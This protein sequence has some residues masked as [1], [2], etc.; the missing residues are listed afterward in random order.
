MTNAYTP[1]A[2]PG[3]PPVPGEGGRNAAAATPRS[4][5]LAFEEFLASREKD[6]K[7]FGDKRFPIFI[8]STQGG[9]I[10]AASAASTFLSTLQVRN[11]NFTRHLFAVSAVSGGSV[12]SAVFH[13]AISKGL[14]EVDAQHAAAKPL[15]HSKLFI[16]IRRTLA[17]DHLS[18]V[19]GLVA[20][21]YLEKV[22]PWLSIRRL[23]GTS[24][25]PGRIDRASALEISLACAFNQQVDRIVGPAGTAPVARRP[26]P[27][28][29]DYANIKGG[30]R[31][32]FASHAP[33]G[34]APSL[35]L[36][37]TFAETGKRVAFANFRLKSAGEGSLHS[38][39]DPDFR[40]I[41]GNPNL[42]ADTS[43]ATAAVASARFPILMPAFVVAAASGDKGSAEV[44]KRWNF[45]D[46]GYADNSGVASAA[47]M[48]GALE[49]FLEKNPKYK[50][51]LKLL[52]LTDDNRERKPIDLDGTSLVDTLAP[53]GALLNVRSSISSREVKLAEERF[54]PKDGSVPWTVKTFRLDQ[55]NFSL[56]L[57]WNISNAKNYFVSLFTTTS[58]R[59]LDE[60][61]AICGKLRPDD[62]PVLSEPA[63][64]T[65][66]RRQVKEDARTIT[67]NRCNLQ[68]VLD[69]MERR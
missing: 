40:R 29:C 67:Q 32:A 60:L 13:A 27:T 46:G 63:M 37:T 41:D 43:L 3:A 38:F 8:V 48:F 7:L 4:L 45:V 14:H 47:A 52:I 58:E 5:E 6:I 54:K 30:L 22:L 12:G 21:D 56:Q 50:I 31:E 57:G 24:D 18:P 53:A 20:A 61:R 49:K 9:G 42:P 23:M 19:L 28:W 2:L 66:Q 35:V 69:L 68:S 15:E 34:S 55:E 25:G 65:E 17:Q 16:A 44:A 62:Q 1:L 36:N 11:R 26:W 10:Y 51:D 59:S 64:P 33:G 39:A